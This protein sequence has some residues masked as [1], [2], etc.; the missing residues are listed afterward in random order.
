[1]SKLFSLDEASRLLEQIRPWM[2]EILTIHKQIM[3]S[4]PEL[5]PAMERAAGNGG[6]PVLSRMTDKFDRLD[7][8]LHQI[9]ATGAVV[10]DLTQGLL[11]FPA[12]RGEQEVY[13]C[14]KHGE[15]SIEFWHDQES[16]FAGRQPISS[17]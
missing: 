6:S 13:L 5:W 15:T 4:Q 11:D 7:H 9:Q 1:M 12:M 2:D 17:F 3:D 14:W 10:K 16:G 8:L